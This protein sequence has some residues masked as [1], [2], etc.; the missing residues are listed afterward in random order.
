MSHCYG[1]KTTEV[2]KM[3]KTTGLK[4]K[5]L[6]LLVCL[7]LVLSLFP[8]MTFAESDGADPRVADRS[9]MDD[10]KNYFGPT[11]LDTE[12]A[13]GVW[14]DKSV[15]TDAEAFRSYGITMKD[16][17]NHFL[18]ALSAIASNKSIVGY[19]AIPTD[20]VMVLDLSNSMSSSSLSEMVEA[21]NAAI[22]KLQ[23]LN[24]NNRISVVV[25]SGNA[26]YRGG[27]NLSNSA[28]VLLPLDRYEG[29]DQSGQEVFLSYSRKSDN[30][31]VVSGVKGEEN[32]WSGDRYPSEPATG[33][34]YIQAGLQLA[35]E[36]FAA[37]K[38]VVVTEG[39]QKGVTRMPTV[40]LMSDGA[41]TLGTTSYGDVDG[42]THG[43]GSSTS[44]SIAFLTQLS[45]ALLRVRME[46]KYGRSGLFY[47]LGLD[48]E[49]NDTARAVLNPASNTIDIGS[50]WN[51]YLS[52]TGDSY[53]TKSFTVSVDPDLKTFFRAEDGS[54]RF[55][56][57]VSGYYLASSSNNSENQL[58]TAFDRIVDQI[59]IQSKYYPTYA[60]S[61]DFDQDG[62]LTFT[63]EL[64]EYMEVKDIKG[65]T[66]AG[67][68]YR[69]SALA[70]AVTEGRFGNITSGDPAQLTAL[71]LEM[72]KSITVRTGCSE[73]EAL[74]LAAQAI[75]AG[76]IR[77]SGGEYSN[78]IGWYADENG[79]Y[80]GFWDGG[81]VDPSVGA[82]YVNKSY[83]FVGSVGSAE[84][85]NQTDML[86]ISVQVHRHIGL[87]HEQVIYR[88]PAS[89]VPMVEYEVSFQGTELE[90][91]T[92]FKMEISGATEPLRLIFEV[93]LRS[94]I[95][96][97]NVTDKVASDYAHVGEE[98]YAFYTN[99]WGEHTH[100]EGSFVDSHDATYMDFRPSL[101]NERYYY[102]SNTPIL[103]E[104][105]TAVTYDPKTRDGKY[106]FKATY[107]HGTAARLSPAE[108]KTVLVEISEQSLALS[109]YDETFGEWVVPKGTPFRR[110]FNTDDQV[111]ASKKVDPATDTLEYSNYPSLVHPSETSPYRVDACL[112]NNGR[113]I[114]TPE[115]GIALTKE[116]EFVGMGENELF[117]FEIS[118]SG[119]G[120]PEEY[121]LRN[122]DGKLL[123]TAV[124]QEG[125]KLF[126]VLRP[127][128]TVYV[129]GI[130]TGTE[131][132]V[133]EILPAGSPWKVKS[134]SGAEGTVA[135]YAF[136]EVLFVNTPTTYGNLLINKTVKHPFGDGYA[137]PAKA[138]DVTVTFD[139]VADGTT[140]SVDGE[141]RVI[142]EGK[143]DL[144]IAHGQTVLIENLPDGASYTVTEKAYAGF[145][146][147]G[148]GLTGVISDETNAEA[149]LVNTYA[150]AAADVTLSHVGVKHLDGR[151]WKEGDEFTFTLQLFNGVRW[152]DVAGGIRTVTMDSEEYS[153]SFDEILKGFSFDRIGEYRFRVLESYVDLG[154]VI[155]DT[156]E[157]NFTVTVAD[158]DFSGKLK[159]TDVTTQSPNSFNSKSGTV[160]VHDVAS[161]RWAV[162]THFNNLYRVDGTASVSVEIT[163]EIRNETG[164]PFGKDGFTFNL[165]EVR[166][167]EEVLLG[168]IL[169]D[170]N[171]KGKFS[172]S[173]DAGRLGEIMTFKVREIN[174][175]REGVIYD[176]TEKTF[177]VTLKDNLDGSVSA[178]V[179]GKNSD[180]FAASFTNTYA[181]G[182]AALTVT[183]EKTLVGR[184]LK[185]GEFTFDLYRCDADFANPEKVASAVNEGKTFTLTDTLSVAGTYHYLVREAASNLPYVTDDKA[186]FRLTVTVSKGEGA[187][188]KAEITSVVKVGSDETDLAI[189]FTNVYEPDP[190]GL[191]ISGKKTLAGRALKE[192]E[193]AFILSNENGQIARVT[194]AANGNF[195]FDEIEFTEKG[196][197]V[198]TVREDLSQKL[199][200]VIYDE[201]VFTVTVDVTDDGQGNLSKAVTLKKGDASVEEIVFANTFVPASV[202]GRIFI[203]KLLNNNTQTVIGLDGFEFTLSGESLA[204]P[205]TVKSDA[206]GNGSF[207][208]IPYTAEDIGR[209]FRYTVTEVDGG[210][211]NMVYDKTAITVTAEITVTEDGVIVPLWTVNGT[212]TEQAVATFT[213]L[214]HE[215]PSTSDGS[216][217]LWALLALVGSGFVASAVVL[218][219]R[220]AEE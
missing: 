151:D 116:M 62:F 168:S 220:N 16:G 121:A 172:F 137:M 65:L 40:V 104:N 70:R 188:L 120:F 76:Q 93:G 112:G 169:S 8:G 67:A 126:V 133:S 6:S 30:I 128:E 26:P 101:E 15:F 147:S 159:I 161:D 14:G 61:G 219:K 86:Y 190:T 46:E 7:A 95:N 107:F 177:T 27:Y 152:E 184:E 140:V 150:P 68:L 11:V 163:K 94:D 9:T 185:D 118:L 77:Y 31:S 39:P 199:A 28:A 79:K 36:Q 119:S 42:S 205:L 214:Y 142:R 212:A 110:I 144:S 154:G 210:R 216:L 55:H 167:T 47:T 114:L 91:G 92:D 99:S 63:D 193:F 64:G 136:G 75:R 19:S 211:E 204:A 117:T 106:Y 38:D 162:T 195:L 148:T 78:Y 34:T 96:G 17:E 18:V 134:V 90:T 23:N 41:P 81:E 25:Y 192:S 21:A 105:G 44:T 183:G 97:V 45:S 54:Y 100:S 66:L 164:V 2:S 109:V 115:Q 155:C 194:N 149:K 170:G 122:Y 29:V 124:L 57:Y 191:V 113:L 208:A 179:N 22:R 20:T 145:T 202:E 143:L 166:G 153:F 84:E 139:G 123:S 74:S 157:K 176:A 33:A 103:D 127:G 218:K 10:W 52:A 3:K 85:Y 174:D 4:R 73:Q 173:I 187:N 83:G 24:R 180:T 146:L 207:A 58:I 215:N 72:I 111:Y 125:N 203:K 56:N 48:I 189:G 197:Y 213:N 182:S 53:S 89:L 49:E 60:E 178:L 175:G 132:S 130:P 80:L 13:G 108:M 12:N 217:R 131:Y 135:E 50:Y 51:N 59:I 165:Y 32:S 98:G 82:T 141:N 35:W 1:S 206:E 88:I 69:G 71:G 129:T 200:N 181:L 171:G 196:T 43:N 37:V 5:A 156:A 138:F 186:E 201:S 160:V 158:G 102:V 87:G 198:Y 209:I